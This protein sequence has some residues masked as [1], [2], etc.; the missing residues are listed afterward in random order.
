MKILE[1]IKSASLIGDI[2][3]DF[4]P[5]I[6]VPHKWDVLD[7]YHQAGFN[8]LGIA[9]AGEM[10]TLEASIK[11]LARQRAYIRKN[12]D[13]FVL[14]D[15]AEDFLRAKIENK[16][17]LIF[18]F[19]GSTS[20]SNDVNMIEIYYQ[21][22]VRYILLSYNSRNSI[23]DGLLEKNDA[24]LSQFG[25]KIIQEMNRVGML[26]DLSHSGIRT[27]LEIIEAS[28]DPVIFSHSNAYGV[29]P[30]I[31]NLTD[32]QIL[33]LAKKGGV[34]GINGMGLIL[35]VEN[36]NPQ[37]WVDHVEYI[38]NLIGNNENIA[39]GLDLIYFHD[40]LPLFFEK[41]GLDYP[42]GYIGSMESLQPEAI[43]SIIEELL[44]RKFSE[45]DIQKIL[46]GNFLRIA[47]KV[48]KK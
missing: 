6:E 3:M 32:Q 11:Y 18:W 10:T 24:G 25:L 40:M 29:N 2:A 1:K 22:G 43:D 38:S 45:R 48:W 5:E 34:I 23:G 31:R 15:S 12:S 9:V 41:A 21:L 13:K 27:S 4:I 16:L 26:I 46:G 30:H 7:R 14:I 8:Y 44:K 39:L 36:P 33:S 37:K 19:Q 47:Q 20:L 35:G 42:K 17:G 28:K